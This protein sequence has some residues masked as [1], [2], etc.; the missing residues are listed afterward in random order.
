MTAEIAVVSMLLSSTPPFMSISET[1][2]APGAL[3]SVWTVTTC[4]A[5]APNIQLSVSPAA[6]S[7]LLTLAEVAPG[8]KLM[9]AV[10]P[11]GGP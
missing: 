3:E 10:P 1:T 2:I 6:I 7:L 8:A 9:R 5:R 4:P 11:G